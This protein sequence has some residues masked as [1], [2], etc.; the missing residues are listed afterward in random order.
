VKSRLPFLLAVALIAAAL[1]DA[2]VE[3]ISN[4]GVLG[5]GYA[6]ND[7]LSVIPTLVAGASL[8]LLLLCR[9]CI[10]LLRHSAERS[11]LLL[12]VAKQISSHSPL[13]D[14]RFVLVLQ[15]VALFVMENCEQ[16]CLSGKLLGG[17]V[18][19]GGPVWFGLCMH[20]LIGSLCTLLVRHAIRAIVRRCAVL[21]ATALE[22]LLDACMLQDSSTFASRCS[23]SCLLVHRTLR[24]HQVGERA[25]P[26]L[27]ALA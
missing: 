21:I 13:D 19:L 9:R 27:F 11:D 10:A 26:L 1:G 3:T 2:L 24:V 15:F 23:L 6:D 20:L 17:T 18:W 8:A 7:H 12:A 16:L 25:P 4:T 5:S 22:F 14:V